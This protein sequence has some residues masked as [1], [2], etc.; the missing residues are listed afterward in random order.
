MGGAFWETLGQDVRFGLR[1]LRKSRSFTG[2]AV[3]TL[4]LTIGA[5][6]V[7]FAALNSIILRPLNVPRPESL[8]SIHRIDKNFPGKF[9]AN[10]SYPDYVD[11]R[12]RNHSFEGLAGYDIEEAG[13][14]TG[15]EPSAS[16]ALTVT[17]NYFDV[18]GIR[19][20]RGRFFHAP[21]EHGPNSMPYLVL[22]HAFWHARF[23]DDPGVVGRVVRVNKHPFTILGVAPPGFNGTL[24]FLGPDFFAPIVDKEWFGADPKLLERRNDRRTVFMTFGHL[25]PGVTP[26]Q[27]GADLNAI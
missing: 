25:K 17:S 27:A 5:N 8:Y 3:F 16:W 23:H 6:A 2:V 19:P 18:L 20:F 26:K 14:D 11:L 1:M 7:V 12:D 15:D 24:L 4:A 10:Q 21:D 22:S 13:L 9:P